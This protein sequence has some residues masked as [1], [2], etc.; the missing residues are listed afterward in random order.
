MRSN[1]LA[2]TVGILS[3]DTW[4]YYINNFGCLHFKGTGIE[5]NYYLLRP[6]WLNN[7]EQVVNKRT[8]LIAKEE[9]VLVEGVDFI[10]SKHLDAVLA[11]KLKYHSNLISAEEVPDVE[12]F[13][14]RYNLVIPGLDLRWVEKAVEAAILYRRLNVIIALNH[15][16]SEILE[17][18]ANGAKG[19]YKTILVT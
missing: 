7:G 12:E 10:I 15:L 9:S 8:F 1:R 19:I 5:D 13:L 4:R 17:E 6:I 11:A 3:V 18:N 14:I 2:N 16:L